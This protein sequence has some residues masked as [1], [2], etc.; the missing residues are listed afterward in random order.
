MGYAPCEKAF[1]THHFLNDYFPAT[2]SNMRLLCWSHPLLSH[3]VPYRTQPS[4]HHSTPCALTLHQPSSPI[5][6][7]SLDWESPKLRYSLDWE[8]VHIH[9]IFTMNVQDKRVVEE[10]DIDEATMMI[11]WLHRH[12]AREVWQW[13]D[14]SCRGK[15]QGENLDLQMSR[16]MVR[17]RSLMASRALNN[18]NL[19]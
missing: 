2:S 3:W 6:K 18:I 13:Q 9:L 11:F 5:T 4:P 10:N 8:L 12:H 17:R 14:Q 15:Q 1:L 16:S 7:T 19:I